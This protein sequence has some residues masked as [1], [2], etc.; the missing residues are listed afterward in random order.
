MFVGKAG[1]YPSGAPF[2][3]KLMT[4]PTN[5]RLGWKGFPRTNILAYYGNKY[6]TTVKSFIV[7]A[8][9]K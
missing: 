9:G 3:G 4:F 8:H 7:Q 6:I 5:I 2:S 1:A